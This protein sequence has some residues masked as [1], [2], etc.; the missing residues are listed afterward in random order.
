MEYYAFYDAGRKYYLRIGGFTIVRK[1]SIQIILDPP[2]MERC[3][4]DGDELSHIVDSFLKAADLHGG[5]PIAINLIK[6][7]CI[8]AKNKVIVIDTHNKKVSAIV[9]SVEKGKEH[10]AAQGDHAKHHVVIATAEEFDALHEDLRIAL[11]DT[12]PDVAT[13]PKEEKLARA[14][15]VASKPVKVAKEKPAPKAKAKGVKSLIRALFAV[16]GARHSIVEICALTAGTDVSVK[17]AI[18]DLRSATYCKPGEPL[19]LTRLADGKY[20]LLAAGEAEALAAA[21]KAKVDA[22]K[23]AKKDAAAEKKEVVAKAAAEKK[24]VASKAAKAAAEKKVAE[25]AVAVREKA[26]A[27]K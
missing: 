5:D 19:F 6:E 20:A 18:S 8:M 16:T 4:K 1:P 23:A 12:N 7:I 11:A 25:K 13:L 9:A 14:Y 2:R 24:E 21:V 10:V 17:T 26:A 3:Y 22:E 15:E 27:T